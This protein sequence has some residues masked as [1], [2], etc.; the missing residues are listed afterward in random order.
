MINIGKTIMGKQ[1]V[2][3]VLHL[4]RVSRMIVILKPDLHISQTESPRSLSWDKS[5][6]FKQSSCTNFIVPE[7]LQGEMRRLQGDSRS[8]QIR[9]V[10]SKG[11]SGLQKIGCM[12]R[13][14]CSIG[15]YNFILELQVKRR[16]SIEL[17]LSSS[18]LCPLSHLT[19][20]E[21]GL[22]Q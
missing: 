21:L 16:D 2:H 10:G 1:L 3:V 17:T 4:H 11:V 20:N 12:R 22:G 14:G 18:D 6:I 19:L 7:H 13:D 9:Q 5:Q 15:I 8:K